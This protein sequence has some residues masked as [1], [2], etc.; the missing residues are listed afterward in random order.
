MQQRDEVKEIQK[1]VSSE[2]RKVKTWRLL[3]L[4][5]VRN[6][7]YPSIFLISFAAH[8]DGCSRKHRFLLFVESKRERGL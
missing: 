3:V 5:T 1:L 4:A 8:R 7:Q 6:E 2:T